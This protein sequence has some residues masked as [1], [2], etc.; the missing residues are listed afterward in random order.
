MWRPQRFLVNPQPNVRQS[1]QPLDGQS[2]RL[3]VRST[4]GLSLAERCRAPVMIF[5]DRDQSLHLFQA[6][7]RDAFHALV[8][9]NSSVARSRIDES[10][11]P[12][13][14]LILHACR[15][16]QEF[17]NEARG[18]FQTALW[19]VSHLH[20]RPMLESSC[21]NEGDARLKLNDLAI[22]R[23]GERHFATV[24]LAGP[25]RREVNLIYVPLAARHIVMMGPRRRKNATSDKRDTGGCQGSWSPAPVPRGQRE[26]RGSKRSALP[27]SPG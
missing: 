27:R 20:C 25:F 24:N 18:A 4:G 19:N 5:P 8:L 2:N 21:A 17:P 7:R 1:L 11:N 14:R 12:P 13:K 16:C 26:S 9:F 10:E 15:P 6:D 23:I 22:H 3:L